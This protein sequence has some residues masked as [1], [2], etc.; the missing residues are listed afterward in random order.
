MVPHENLRVTF[1]Y[2]TKVFILHIHFVPHLSIGGS[3]RQAVED[4][5]H[6]GIIGIQAAVNLQ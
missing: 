3:H 1:L 5:Y 2:N 6:L 4:M